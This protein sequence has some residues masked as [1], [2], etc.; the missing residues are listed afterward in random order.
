M[1]L[2]LFNF[3]LLLN[4]EYEKK[5]SLIFKNKIFQNVFYD[6]VKLLDISG[7]LYSNYYLELGGNKGKVMSELI[8]DIYVNITDYS[9]DKKKIF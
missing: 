7:A 1:T 9:L 3:A 2:N 8:F 6:F 4:L 5:D